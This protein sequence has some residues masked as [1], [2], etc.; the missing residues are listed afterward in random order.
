MAFFDFLNR[1]NI[2]QQPI[3]ERGV[4]DENWNPIYGNFTFNQWSA[5]S[6]SKSLKL[7]TV[8]RC[9][10]LI[11][12]SIGSLPLLPYTY[13]NPLTGQKGDWKYV[14]EGG[15]NDILNV[16]PNKIMSAFTFKKLIPIH[17]LLKG[18]AYIYVNRNN[19]GQ[20]IELVLLNPDLVT[21]VFDGSGNPTYNY[22]L[23]PGKPTFSDSEIIHILNYTYDGVVGESTLFYAA[24]SLGITMD[25]ETNASNFFK[26]GSNLS[27]ILS[28]IAGVN[29]GADKAKK[30]KQDWI[31]STS[32]NVVGSVGNG[33]VVLDA[34]LTYQ[35]IS[36]SPKDSQLLESRQFNVVDVC[37]FFN[38]PPALCFSD[39]GKYSTPEQAQLDYLNNCLQPLI[40]KIENEFYRKLFPQNQWSVTDLKFSIENLIRLDANGRADYFTKMFQLGGYTPNEI[41]QKI[42]SQQ[43]MVGGNRAFIQVN[44]QP[45][46]NL[47]AEQPGVNPTQPIDNKLK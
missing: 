27:G 37:R 16:Q 3:E 29:I 31:N 20:V 7:S 4:V 38:T 35:P 23:I 13:I 42:D 17:L 25:S 8:Y 9:V 40:E 19:N 1:K 22:P 30:A 39:S 32:S 36:I 15:L 14:A 6:T 41:R 33:V 18:N 11:S 10:E 47:I 43:P 46:D 44:V 21:V 34:G 26:G 5:Y 28:P 2:P 12:N 24:T 45:L